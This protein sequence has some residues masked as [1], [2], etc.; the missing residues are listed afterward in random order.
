MIQMGLEIAEQGGRSAT[1]FWDG[2]ITS[3]E[4]LT[5]RGGQLR[6]TQTLCFEPANGP[7]PVRGHPD[8]IFF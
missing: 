3:N 8:P 2:K 6:T 4:I 1:A 5:L 7:E